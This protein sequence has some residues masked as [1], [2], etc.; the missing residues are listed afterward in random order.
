M[1]ISLL[2]LSAIILGSTYCLG[3]F[4]QRLFPDAPGIERFGA[5]LVLSAGVVLI[6]SQVLRP[7]AGPRLQLLVFFVLLLLILLTTHRRSERKDMGAPITFTTFAASVPAMFGV[8][9]FWLDHPLNPEFQRQY[10]LDVPFFQAIST[11]LYEFGPWQNILISGLPTRYHWF[12]Y[13]WIGALDGW[14]EAEPYLVLT[15]LSPLIS[16]VA[17]ASL[18]ASISWRCARN[19]KAVFVSVLLAT[20]SISFFRLGIGSLLPE[21]SPSH[22]VSV[23]WMLLAVLM[24]LEIYRSGVLGVWVGLSLF[25][26][27]AMAIG[28]KVTHGIILVSGCFGLLVASRT[29]QKRRI[30]VLK[31]FLLVLSGSLIA[32]VS[33]LLG[34]TGNGLK[35]GVGT[36]SPI[37]FI[38]VPVVISFRLLAWTGRLAAGFFAPKATRDSPLWALK[39][40]APAIAI[41][42]FLGFVI[43]TH[44]GGSNSYFMYSAS[45][46]LVILAGLGVAQIWS[47]WNLRL[48]WAAVSVSLVLA[49]GSF[50]WLLQGDSLVRRILPS[51]AIDVGKISDAATGPLVWMACLLSAALISRKRDLLASMSVMLLVFVAIG[52]GLANDFRDLAYR[53]TSGSI[54]V[55]SR[56]QEEA[57]NWLRDSPADGEELVITNRFC[58]RIE[59]TPPDCDGPGRARY[60]WVAASTEH[61]MLVEGYEFVFGFDYLPESTQSRVRMSTEFAEM[62]TR[63]LHRALWNMGGRWVW[64]D[65]TQPSAMDWSGF[66]EVAFEND[67]V[68]IVRLTEP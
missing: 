6:V 4:W 42:G 31:T 62:P 23:A 58:E 46:V 17:T 39:A 25:V 5:G 24:I 56:S 34:G 61:K 55:F 30:A 57:A 37:P 26:I 11:G 66:G 22:S 51:G 27:S 32:F 65:L 10:F 53:S 47:H 44:P 20:T 13:G 54:A 33:F 1:I 41:T 43:T 28:G 68:R 38:G 29:D 7:I 2:V 8:I 59:D 21:Y 49:L 18:T 35:F 45:S 67:A 19:K 36:S 3:L 50:C 9:G 14:S 52:M 48:K 40:M 16:L 60:F 63:D 12:V 64:L 15:R